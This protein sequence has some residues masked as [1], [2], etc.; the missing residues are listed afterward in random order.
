MA[1]ASNPI[2]DIINIS[3]SAALDDLVIDF[4]DMIYVGD[5]STLPASQDDT[6]TLDWDTLMLGSGAAPAIGAT[7]TIWSS[8][9]SDTTTTIATRNRL[10]LQGT[11][12]DIVINGVSLQDTLQGIQERLNILTPNPDLEAEWDELRE[13]GQRYRALE[14]QCQEKSKIWNQLKAMPPPEIK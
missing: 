8:D 10:N 12:A 11:D 13:L 14:K 4:P 7:S 9:L 2:S 5:M 3:E 6:I 1:T